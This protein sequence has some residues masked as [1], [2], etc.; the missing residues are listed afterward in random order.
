MEGAC[1][2]EPANLAKIVQVQF[3]QSQQVLVEREPRLQC[4]TG[5]ETWKSQDLQLFIYFLHRTLAF[6]WFQKGQP[7][8]CLLLLDSRRARNP[9][10]VLDC[11]KDR[12]NI[13]DLQL[14]I[15]WPQLARRS[16]A[17]AMDLQRICKATG[18]SAG[19]CTDSCRSA[20]L[21]EDLQPFPADLQLLA[22][23][24]CA[25]GAGGRSC[26]VSGS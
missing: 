7:A 20:A 3:L 16:A 4:W 8:I 14:S 24:C 26:S 22:G 12:S 5:R 1:W 15:Y 11:E 9:F 17:T 10:T 25:E 2:K 23:I 19:I 18:R 6:V 21:P 13:R